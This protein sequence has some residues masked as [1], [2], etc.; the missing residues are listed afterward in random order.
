MKPRRNPE[1]LRMLLRLS[2][3]DAPPPR[4]KPVDVRPLHAY[5][6]H[7]PTAHRL[8]PSLLPVLHL[9]TKFLV[10]RLRIEH[11][12]SET[13]AMRAVG[14]ARARAAVSADIALARARPNPEISR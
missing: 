3:F 7:H 10:L 11:G 14:I 13:T 2:Q 5:T 4:A 12:V 9:R 1:R 8:A 6:R